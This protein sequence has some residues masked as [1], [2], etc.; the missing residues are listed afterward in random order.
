M[1][2]FIQVALLL[3]TLMPC[4]AKANQTLQYE[5]AIVEISGKLTKGKFQHPNGRWIKFYS[6]EI[7]TPAAI[8]KDGVNTI[9]ISES[10]IKK[11]QLY[12]DAPK[13]GKDTTSFPIKRST[14]RGR[15]SIPIPHGMYAR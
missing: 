6:I 2:A 3:L 11:I 8:T 5:P 4:F 15:C 9:N 10:G 1:K 12:S 14:Q 13:S 7:D